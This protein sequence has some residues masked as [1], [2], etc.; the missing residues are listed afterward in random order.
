MNKSEKYI[1]VQF[2]LLC[3]WLIL[4]LFFANFVKDCEITVH[5][6]SSLKM[7]PKL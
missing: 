1:F 5:Y 7:K 3:R 6:D 2:H 4:G